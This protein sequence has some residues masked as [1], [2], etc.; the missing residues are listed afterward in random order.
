VIFIFF[1]LKN[2]HYYNRKIQAQ[3]KKKYYSGSKSCRNPIFGD[4]VRCLSSFS[5]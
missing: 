3:S 2:I 5:A 4:V 1:E